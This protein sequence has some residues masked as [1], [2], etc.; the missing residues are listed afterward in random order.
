MILSSL[1]E[2]RLDVVDFAQASECKYKFWIVYAELLESRA[3]EKVLSSSTHSLRNLYDIVCR[4][5]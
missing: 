4:T 2:I 5:F 3:S 1:P